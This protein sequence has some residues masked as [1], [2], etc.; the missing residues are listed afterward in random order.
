MS[1]VKCGIILTIIDMANPYHKSRGSLL[2][3]LQWWILG[4]A[5][6]V[7]QFSRLAKILE[8]ETEGWM[9][10][11]ASAITEY[12]FNLRYPFATS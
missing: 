11:N 1:C 9:N 10:V 3:S 7:F 4:I 5:F 12:C 6:G 8:C 2:L